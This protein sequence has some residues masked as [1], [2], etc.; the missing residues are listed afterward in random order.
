MASRSRET[1]SIQRRDGN[2]ITTTTNNKY[3]EDLE[4]S[5]AGRTVDSRSFK[6]RELTKNTHFKDIVADPK[7][8]YE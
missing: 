6:A 8:F 3:E 2:V 1:Y 4:F 5:C 7:E